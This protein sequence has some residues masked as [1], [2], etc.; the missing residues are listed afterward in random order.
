[1]SVAGP[2][3]APGT[4][5]TTGRETDMTVTDTPGIDTTGTDADGALVAETSFA[6]QSLWLLDRMDPG[7]PTY[8]V[9]AA[10][11]LH[12]SLDVDALSAALDD[13][14]ARHESLRTEFEFDGHEPVQVV[15]PHLHIDLPVHDVLAADLD[16]RI[17]A[18]V[19][20][21]FDLAVAPLLR[22]VLLK[23][24]PTNHVAVL[25][26]HHLVTDGWSSAILFTELSA[27]YEARSTGRNPVLPPLPIQY[28][29]YAAWQHDTLA[30]E[31]MDEMITYWRETLH[32]LEPLPMPT[33]RPH[34]PD[35]SSAG[36]LYAFEIPTALLDRADALAKEAEATPYMLYLAVF[37][38]LLSR[39]SAAT[40]VA[41]ASPVAG[42]GRPE[43]AGLIGFF[44]NTLVLRV[45]TSGDP[46]F[47]ELLARARAACVGGYSH[48]DLPY[49]KLVSELRPARH[50]GLGGPFA[51]VMLSLQNLPP[52]EWRAGGLVFEPRDVATRTAKF[53]LSLELTPGPDVA[54][55]TIEF[56]TEL[57]DLDTV[58]RLGRHFLLM[59]EAAVAQPAT[60]LS[61]LP[62]V[63]PVER[64]AMA[65]RWAGPE[66][67][68]TGET[69]HGAFAR[70]AAAT[71]DAVAVVQGEHRIHYAELDRRSDA[72][73]RHLR[74]LGVD[75]GARAAV[76]L[77]RGPDLVVAQLA[78]LKA[79]GAYLPVDPEYPAE[80]VAL[81]FADGGAAVVLTGDGTADLLPAGSP[82]AVD[83]ADVP[84]G[85]P[86]GPP[87]DATGPTDPAYVIFTSGSTGRP[88]GA[89]NT[90][91]G[92][93]N[94]ARS[95]VAV[96]GFTPADRSMQLAPLGFDV[97]AEELFPHLLGGGSVAFPPAEVPLATD[98]LW[99]CVAESGATVLSTTPSRLLAISDTDRA[100]VPPGLRTVLFG[101][102]AAPTLRSLAPWAA[103]SGRLVQV[104]GVTEAACTA[105]VAE[106]D[107]DG[108]A[109]EPVALG[110]PTPGV[111]VH[112]LDAWMEPVP[113]GIVGELYLGGTQVGSGYLRAPAATAARF[114][115]DPYGAPGAR[116]YR[117]GD[118]VRPRADGSLRFAGRVDQQVK[119]RGFRVEPGE[120][121][122]VLAEHPAL[123]G[124]AVV[125]GPDG[126]GGVRLVAYP[127][128]APGAVEVDE[129]RAHL[130]ARLP[131]WMVPSA[132]VPVESLP[133]TPNGKV[134]RAALP[135]P[136]GRPVAVYVAPRTPVEEA[137][138]GIWETVLG[139]DRVGVHDDFFALG[140]NSLAAV[141]MV[142]QIQEHLGVALPLRAVFTGDPTVEGVGT[143]VFEQLVLD[144]TGE[145][146]R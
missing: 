13:V 116:L 61:R 28:A 73:A 101:S 114:V 85:R 47:A 38:A 111:G 96:L 62:L 84:S 33:D 137:V 113:P 45:D 70:Q 140:G 10:V 27:C 87:P 122:A 24:G 34:P 58:A 56:S 93:V 43:L 44:V 12:G 126:Q 112:V 115:P 97:V 107:H 3:T 36:D 81:M 19:E 35:P 129:L 76:F 29:D 109:D 131:D 46:T 18:E 25:T 17:Q 16:A 59:L 14:V 83:V 142:A 48:Q 57:F 68:S 146:T 31:G 41:V 89:V 74:A 98:E 71:P 92:V 138:T 22:M 8:N 42:R 128:A 26:V 15:L 90:H 49:E 40:D 88:K 55:A 123:S 66:P 130:S 82:P 4:T 100:A 127:V 11:R 99:A 54:R 63:E 51:Q 124:C 94:L 23:L 20:R 21:P 121:E 132:W 65:G 119:I 118:L 144:D 139:L 75:R 102:E 1:M 141:R 133:L 136:D 53:D 32:G 39:H 91:A 134:D 105:L 117:T 69:V 95:L 7:Q 5:S 106:I 72:L 77:R 86:D 52:Q 145:Q 108:P 135:A 6:Q 80:R 103:W 143:A 78:V 50:A 60:R 104:Y 125:A 110:S 30:G 2:T 9:L 120:V 64:D 67:V 79:G 37:A